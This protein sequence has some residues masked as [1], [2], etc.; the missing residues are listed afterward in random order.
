MPIRLKLTIA[1]DGRPY[2]GWQSQPGGKTVQDHLQQAL[3]EIAKQPMVIHGSGRTD[4]GVHALGQVAHVE[5]PQ[6]TTMRPGNW[7]RAM[8]SK[9]P[10]TIRVMACEEAPEEFHARFSACGKIYHYDICTAPV[11]PPIGPGWSGTCRRDWIWIGSPR[12]W[13][14]CVAGTIF[15]PLRPTAGMKR[16][17]W[18]T[19]ER[20]T[21]L[22]LRCWRTVVASPTWVMG[23]STRWCVC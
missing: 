13:A 18:T 5:V 23:F 22:S 4:T 17:R 21:P 15:M 20:C 14:G 12:R 7:L 10:A 6:P 2:T 8:N 19:T 1:Y 3:G 9:L 11:L 16:R